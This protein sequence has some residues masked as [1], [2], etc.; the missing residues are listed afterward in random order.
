MP[1]KL[2]EPLS[3]AAAAPKAGAVEVP[4]EKGAGA[5]AG[6]CGAVVVVPAGVEVKEKDNGLALFTPNI[7][8]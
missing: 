1:P 8:N 4:N 5:G 6:F 3:G 2:N 7:I